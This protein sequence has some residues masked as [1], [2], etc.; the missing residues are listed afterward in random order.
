MI[1]FSIFRSASLF[2][3]KA[4]DETIHTE[5][6][7]VAMVEEQEQQIPG[8]TKLGFGINDDS[9]RPFS[10]HWEKGRLLRVRVGITHPA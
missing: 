7:K 4:C 3:Q 8:L 10:K 1:S 2:L 5:I 9:Y 6:K